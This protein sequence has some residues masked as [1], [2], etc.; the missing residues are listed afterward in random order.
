VFDHNRRILGGISD[1]AHRAAARTLKHVVENL[2]PD[3]LA[4]DS[5]IHFSREALAARHPAE[6]SAGQRVPSS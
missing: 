4:R 1:D 3:A 6:K 2:A 5:I